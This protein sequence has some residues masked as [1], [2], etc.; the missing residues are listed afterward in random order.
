[1]EIIQGKQHFPV[2]EFTDLR[3]MLDQ[4]VDLYG[5]KIAFKF[6]DKP[7]TEPR[8]RTYID[9][10]ADYRALGTALIAMGLRGK[11]IAIVGDNSY[12]WRVAHTAITGGA[13]IAVPLDRMLPAEE[14]LNLIE[15]AAVEAVFYDSSFHDNLLPA[16]EKNPKLKHAICLRPALL[17]NAFQENDF[18]QSFDRLLLWGQELIRAGDRSWLDTRIDPDAV[19]TLLFTSGTTSMAKAVML[20][21]RN[22]CADI[23]GLAGVVRLDPGIRLLSV[24]PLHHTFENTCGLYMALY[25]GAQIHDTD[26][27]RYIQKN[28]QEYQINMVIGVPLLFNNFYTRIIDALRKSGK[29]KLIQRMIPFTQSMRKIGIDLRK[30]IY[31]RVLAAFGGSF[32]MGICGAAPINADVISFFDA[33]GIRLLEGYG[34]TEAAP[35]ISG[36]NSKVFVP[37]TVGQPLPGV[38]VAIDNDQAGEIGEILARGDNI[39]PGYYQDEEATAAAIDVDGWLHTGDLGHIAP[40]SGCLI[41]TGRR[42]S[43]IVLKSGKKVF[44]EEIEFLFGQY[45]SIKESLVWGDEE[46]GD[47]VISAKLV[48]D[49]EKLEQQTGQKIDEQNIKK[50]LEQIISDINSRMPTFKGIRQYVYSF[51][52]M[53]KTTTRKIRRPI[54]ISGLSRL[55]ADLRLQWRDINGKNIDEIVKTTNEKPGPE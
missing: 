48:L 31:C 51:Q 44:P 29:E 28:M 45:E 38:T 1:M 53:V 5:P 6:R 41:I 35:V 22:V 13:G 8:T 43:M 33:I 49:R 9:F 3:Q 24:L 54:E 19:M 40:D 46:A 11:N 55:M 37:G 23:R 32:H 14:L 4:S 36:C 30:I 12:A 18:R 16:L 10:Q 7:D 21:H 47:I 39:M 2:R 34:L 27:L 42:K 20:S 15:R 50:V 25:V 26:G 17:K 52:E